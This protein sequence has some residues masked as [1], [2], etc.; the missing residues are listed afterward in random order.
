MNSNWRDRGCPV[1]LYASHNII[2]VLD[3]VASTVILHKVDYLHSDSRVYKVCSSDFDR[4][5]PGKHELDGI[6]TVHDASETDDR[7][8]DSLCHLPD[9]PDGDGAHC[10]T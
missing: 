6:A 8:F 1:I 10:G 2:D 3:A 5:R 7:D 4:A 9:H